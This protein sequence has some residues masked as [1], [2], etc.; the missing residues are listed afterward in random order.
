ML[1]WMTNIE[2]G[3]SDD[4]LRTFVHKYSHEVECVHVRR[5]DGDGSRPAALL[6]FVGGDWASVPRLAL[7]L[8]G[9]YWKGRTL[10]CSA[11]PITLRNS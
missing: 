7:R 2:P 3:T 6:S 5:I 10:S 1:L 11:E 9:M 4:A 8:N